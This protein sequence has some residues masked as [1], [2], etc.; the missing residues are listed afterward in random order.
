MDIDF[1]KYPYMRD[2]INNRLIIDKERYAKYGM[3]QNKGCFMESYSGHIQLLKDLVSD[4][5][6]Y[7]YVLKLFHHEIPYLYVQYFEDGLVCG[8]LRLSKVEIV[9]GLKKAMEEITLDDLCNDRIK[10]LDNMTQFS[11]LMKE[12]ISKTYDIS[13]DNQ[14]FSIPIRKFF[15]FLSL[16]E[17]DYNKILEE[18]NY[19]ELNNIPRE[20]FIYALVSYFYSNHI[21]EKYFVPK[22]I[23]KR[24]NSLAMSDQVDISFLNKILTSSKGIELIQINPLLK[25]RVF[26]GMSKW[27]TDLEKAIFIYIKLCKILT[28]DEE[29]YVYNQRGDEHKNIFQLTMI[30]PDYNRVVCY[31]FNA[32]YAKFLSELNLNF[33]IQGGDFG[34]EFNGNHAS[35]QFRYDNYI[36]EAD[37]VTNILHGDLMQVKL[38]QPLVGFRCLNNNEQTQAQ[39]KN[40]VTSVYQDVARQEGIIYG[41]ESMETIE[42]ILSQYGIYNLDNTIH[43]SKKVSVLFDKMKHC[44]LEG[45]NQYS[46][47]LQLRMILFDE[48]ELKNNIEVNIIRY[49]GNVSTYPVAIIT[50]NPIHI[51]CDSSDNSYFLYSYNHDF[52]SISSKE[53][54]D[55]FQNRRFQYISNRDPR[56]PG[57]SDSNYSKQKNLRIK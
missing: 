10:S 3:S 11:S 40:I 37:A 44:H 12:D 50:T 43:F 41:V 8:D 45:I 54:N 53:L 26:Q 19:E 42:D 2:I 48:E 20:C 23:L 33:E 52:E 6:Y 25:E 56:I 17:T 21:T 15:E 5:K 14:N 27:Y 4:D 39:L 35:L 13:I 32:I 47:L 31:E 1:D 34:T 24:Y 18:T 51:N 30:T 29:F 57:I 46:Y 7:F 55:C 22:S 49:N 9:D 16:E 38:N 28:Y 36:I